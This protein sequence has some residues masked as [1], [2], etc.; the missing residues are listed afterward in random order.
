MESSDSSSE[1]INLNALYCEAV[2]TDVFPE[3]PRQY[4]L[5]ATRLCDE[6]H[7]DGVLSCKHPYRDEY[8]EEGKGLDFQNKYVKGTNSSI[9]FYI[10]IPNRDVL[11]LPISLPHSVT[12]VRLKDVFPNAVHSYQGSLHYTSASCPDTTLTQSPVYASSTQMLFYSGPDLLIEGINREKEEH[13]VYKVLQDLGIS[14][15]TSPDFSVNE[16]SCTYGQMV[17]T[18]R[19]LAVAEEMNKYG[20][21]SVPN[22][23]AINSYLLKLWV[24]YLN[25][26]T[27]IGIISINCQRQRKNPRDKEVLIGYILKILENVNRPIHIILHGFPITQKA[28]LFQL[29]KYACQ[30]HFAESAPFYTVVCKFHYQTYSPVTQRLIDIEEPNK[31]PQIRAR[32]IEMTIEAR[33]QYLL[34]NF[35]RG[36]VCSNLVFSNILA[37]A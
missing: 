23:F 36:T 12:G 31:D 18:N 8:Y 24:E 20:M 34:D 2:S 27:S 37:V 1:T 25:V 3:I 9:P 26:N 21:L 16:G 29:K 10:P 28:Y 14:I 33:E 15:A 7:N 5:S 17:N 11:K 30:I 32:M 13:S 6:V 22:V 4:A 19:S 35:Y